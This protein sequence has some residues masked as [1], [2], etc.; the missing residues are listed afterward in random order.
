MKEQRKLTGL[1]A[2]VEELL[3]EGWR[4]TAREPLALRRGRERLHYRLGML[5]SARVTP[6]GLVLL[7]PTE[8]GS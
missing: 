1:R 6:V 4:I 8:L 3:S 5:V 2:H 7:R